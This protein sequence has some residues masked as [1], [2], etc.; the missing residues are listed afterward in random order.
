MNILIV[1]D[2]AGMR[3]MIRSLVAPLA[4]EVYEC[5]DGDAA[6]SAYR[7][8]RP[9]WVLMDIRLKQSDGI[10]TTACICAADPKAKVV[11]VTGYDDAGLREAA[12]EAGACGYVLKDDL[13]TLP[14]LLNV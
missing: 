5:A 1:E 7:E 4:A 3:R 12:T 8:H 11:I 6:L 14:S 2:S 9:D 10:A 13:Y